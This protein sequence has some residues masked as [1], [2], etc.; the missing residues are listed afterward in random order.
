MP[1]SM[2]LLRKVFDHNYTETFRSERL[3]EQTKFNIV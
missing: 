1:Q 2:E 3:L